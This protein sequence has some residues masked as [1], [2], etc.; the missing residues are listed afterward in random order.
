[1]R[2]TLLTLPLALSGSAPPRPAPRRRPAYRRPAP[3]RPACRLCLERLEDRTVPSPLLT[4]NNLA[5]SGSNGAVVSNSGTFGDTTAGA[6]VTLTASAGTITQNNSNGTWSWSETTPAGAAQT[7]PVT[8]YAKDSN[9]QTAAVEFWL[10]VGQVFTVTNTG[11]NGGAN[12]ASGAGTG[13][14]RQAI[15]DADNA[16]TTSGPSLIA[17]AI[18]TSD[19]GYNSTTRAF[20]I[21]P[22]SDLPNITSS[23]VIDGY[24]QSGASPNTNPMG[25]ADPSDNAVRNIVLDGSQAPPRSTNQWLTGFLWITGVNSTIRGLLVR[26]VSSGGIGIVD[27]TGSPAT[28]N[29]IEG[30]YIDAETNGVALFGASNNTIGGTDPSARNIIASSGPGTGGIGLIDGYY[31]PASGNLVEGNYV[32]LDASGTSV[33]PGLGGPGIYFVGNHGNI[34]GGS[35]PSA[36]NVISGWPE[37]VA[38]GGGGDP[39]TVNIVEGNYIGTDATGTSIPAIPAPAGPRRFRLGSGSPRTNASAGSALRLLAARDARW[40]PRGPVRAGPQSSGGGGSASPAA[41]AGPENNQ[42]CGRFCRE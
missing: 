16:S 29:A 31:G 1:M 41:A 22:S 9:N 3:R 36:R 42:V 12:P 27:I 14:L 7:G 15:I 40:D 33:I 24:S 19:P 17:F 21:T 8:I 34:V 18:P 30:N 5:V 2:P 38:P 39:K 6:T 32:G 37:Q 26:N 10:N 11:D 13:T 28:G 20:T 4:V 25:G 35:T 23:A